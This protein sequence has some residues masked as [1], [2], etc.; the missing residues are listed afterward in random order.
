[1]TDLR[2]LGDNFTNVTG[3]KAKDSQNNQYTY[4]N[5]TQ[6]D[7]G[8][9]VS[10][11]A[12]VSQTSDTVTENGTY[13]TTL[14]N[15]VTVNVSGGGMTIDQFFDHNYPQGD[16]E[17]TATS[18]VQQTCRERRK[19]TS[20]SAPNCTSI[21]GYGFYGCTSL[22]TV[23]FPK[24]TTFGASNVFDGCTKLEGFAMP[25]GSGQPNT[26]S[27]FKGCSKLKCFDGGVGITHITGGNTFQNCTVFDTIVLRR[28]ASVTAIATSAFSGTPFGS[29]GTGGTL[30]VPSSMISSY[31]SATNW[32]TI[33]GYTNNQ[34]KSIESTHTDQT[35]PIDLTLYYAD[36]TPIPTT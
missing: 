6:S 22:E 9:V 30:Y 14:K 1:M 36:G 8:K 5:L 7:E 13:D 12:L 11:G 35:A 28:T 21:G 33:L 27:T 26:N 29:S 18:I 10:N 32:S 4:I 15:S 20:I 2:I 34:I 25:K 31:Q 23:D 19:I 24:L 16:I 3:I 17:T